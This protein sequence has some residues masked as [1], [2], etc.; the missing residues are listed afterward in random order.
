MNSKIRRLTAV[1]TLTFALMAAIPAAAAPSQD[2][3]RTSIVR[4]IQRVIQRFFGRGARAQETPT[5]PIPQ[6]T[7]PASPPST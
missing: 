5:I 7:A 3:D 2:R 4:V 6:P 1:V